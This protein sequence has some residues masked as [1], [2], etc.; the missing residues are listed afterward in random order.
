[1]AYK[2]RACDYEWTYRAGEKN[3]CPKCGGFETYDVISEV[4]E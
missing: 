4:S 3:F 1:M 2:C